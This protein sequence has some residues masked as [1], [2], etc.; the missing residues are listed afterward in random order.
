MKALCE[1]VVE[2]RVQRLV[3]GGAVPVLAAVRDKVH[4]Q[5][6]RRGAVPVLAAVRD[7]LHG[8]GWPLVAVGL[9]GTVSMRAAYFL[10]SS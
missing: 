6:C 5:T 1:L 10:V 7:K 2:A 4:G 3:V 8:R 9:K